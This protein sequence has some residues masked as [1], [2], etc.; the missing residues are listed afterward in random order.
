MSP[1]LQRQAEIFLLEATA[2]ADDEG[3][4]EIDLMVVPTPGSF[5]L[6]NTHT[7]HRD[8]EQV[9]RSWANRGWGALRMD[10]R[11]YF[12]FSS[13]GFGAAT[14]ARRELKRRTW[15]QRLSSINWNA[16][17][18]AAAFVAAFAAIVAAYLSYLTLVR[19]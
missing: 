4:A 5:G 14:K 9:A 18:A 19:Q 13:E 16:V 3:K 8:I 17:S 15:R 1:R 6:N 12:S 2:Y 11:P 10:G 7:Y